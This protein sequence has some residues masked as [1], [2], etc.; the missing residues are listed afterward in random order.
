MTADRDHQQTI[1]LEIESFREQ[2]RRYIVNEMVPQLDG[3]RHQGYVPRSVWRPFGEMGFMLPEL[4]EAHG[5]AGASLAYQLV[6]QDEL[7][8]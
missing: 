8:P 1:S 2:L 4:D 3:W 6:V 5:G 7:T